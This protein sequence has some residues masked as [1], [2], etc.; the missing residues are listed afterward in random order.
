LGLVEQK[1]QH[2]MTVVFAGAEGKS[3]VEHWP[4][5]HPCGKDLTGYL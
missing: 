1:F 4:M 2:L 3:L 5:N